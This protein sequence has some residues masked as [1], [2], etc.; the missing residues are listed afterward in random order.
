MEQRRRGI[1]LL[2]I[3]LTRALNIRKCR[4]CRRCSIYLSRFDCI[5]EVYWTDSNKEVQSCKNM[6]HL[7]ETAAYSSGDLNKTYND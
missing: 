6:N 1:V 3:A 7:V 4:P 2:N 5:K